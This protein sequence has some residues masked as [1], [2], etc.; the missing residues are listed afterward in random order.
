MNLKTPD[1][2]MKPASPLRG[3]LNVFANSTLPSLTMRWS[4]RPPALRLP[5]AS[6]QLIRCGPYALSVAVAH[7][8]LVRRM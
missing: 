7:L 2:P 6:L 1:Q 4:E 3:G 5:F 8:V